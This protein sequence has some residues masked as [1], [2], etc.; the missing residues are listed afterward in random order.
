MLRYYD[1]SG[2]ADLRR[3]RLDETLR[4]EHTDDFRTR[5]D[6]VA[7]DVD[8]LGQNQR[9]YSGRAQATHELFESLTTTASLGVTRLEIEDFQSD[10]AFGDV[11]LEYT[12]RVPYGRLDA[13]VAG[14][15]NR[16][17]DSERGEPL[18]VNDD[19]V[20]LED[21]QPAVIT[22]RNIVGDTILVT[23]ASGLRIYVEGI[24]YTV[25]VFPT[26]VEI[27]RIIGGAIADGE[28]VLVD[29]VIGPEPAATFDTTNATFSTRYTLEEGFLKGL[30]VYVVYQW[31]D[32]TVDTV[33]PTLFVL[34]ELHDLR[35][36]VDYR[37]GGLTL[38]AERQDHDSTIFPYDTTRL[39]AR[40]ALRL[41]PASALSANVTH[42]TTDYP[43]EDDTLDVDRANLRFYGRLF[44]DL[45]FNAQLIYRDERSE[46]SIDSTG[47]DQLL[48]LTW[49][50]GKTTVNAHLRNSTLDSDTTETTTQE[51]GVA[52]RRTF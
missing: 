35:Y 12:K 44:E 2:L 4:L 1:E 26:H 48:E 43:D 27:R 42:E 46:R 38:M 47:F 5:Y 17:E 34:E 6:I 40:Y 9:F 25:R 8:R 15:L 51:V 3:L 7:E 41:S 52:L 50:K 18:T 37:I 13:S 33:D 19:R 28:T 14:G 49:R 10:Q 29:Y 21:T 22:R 30:G 24:D 20:V 45:D 31:V 36:G 16:Q 39:E 32:Q 11:V 23:D